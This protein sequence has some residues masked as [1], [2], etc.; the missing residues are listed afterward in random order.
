MKKISVLVLFA[1][2][3]LIVLQA[4]ELVFQ[5]KDGIVRWKKNNQ[6]VA[7]FGANY[8]LPSSCDYRAAGY[9]NADRKAMVREDMDHFKRMGWD[10]LRIC[11]WGDFQNSDPDGH[12]IDNDHL[13]MMDYLIAEASRRGIYMLF[14][15]IV[16]Y[17]SQ[18]PEMNDNSNTGYAKLF[19]KNT[20][21]HDE[22]AIKCQINYMTDIL[23]HVNRYTGRCIKDEPN[24]IYV[25]IINEPTQFPNDIPGMVKYINCMCKA[26][27]STGC[28]KLIYYNLSQNFDVAPA[29]QKSMV[30][31]AT[32]AWYPQALNNGH[33]FIDNGLHFVDRYEPL[34]KD[35]LK[36]KSRLVYEFDA[37]DTE[38]GYLLPAMTREYRRGG[39]QFATM[40]SYDEHQTASRNLSW[41]THFLNMVYTPSKAIGGMISA[42]VMKRIPR[43]KHY[44]YYPQNNNFGDFKVDFYQ[45]LGQLNAEDMF[46]Y[47][48]NTTD[49]PKNVKALKHIAGVGSSPVVQYEGT[50]IYFIDKVADNEWKLEVY[51]DIMNV[52]DPFKAGSVNRVARQAVCLNRNIHIQLPGLQTALCIYPGKYTF[53]NN[54]LVNYEALPNQEYYNKEAMKDWKVNNSTL[55]EMPQSRPGVFACEVYGPTLPKQV[56]LYILSGWRGGKRIPMAHKSGFRYETEVDL[57]KY[58][59][60]E[61][62]YHFGIEYTDGKLLFPA[63][64]IG[65]A[66]EFG[67][68][69]QEQYNLRI[70]NNNTTLTLLDKNDNIRK[71]RRSRPH[72]SPDNQVSQ[73]YVGDEMVKAFRIT[74][75]DL[76]RKDTYKLPCDVTLSKYISP[77]IDSR[78]WKTSTP[79]Y[80]RIEAQ[81]L[82]NTD[83]AII[84]F[85]DTEGRGYGN[86]F[87][88]KPDMQQILIP[89]SALR[90]TKG[91][92]LPQEYPGGITPYYYPASTRDNDNVP[93]KWE[94][95]DF[96]QI[97]LRDEIYPVE[98]LKDKGII[99]KK[100]QLVF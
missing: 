89:V 94:N 25:E 96:V 39:I 71:L 86:T 44:G 18:F 23:N 87:S 28:K 56:N 69:E 5:D 77:L 45:D 1:W 63:K 79:K 7:L 27:K 21:I 47:S 90:P 33:R 4:Q 59:L 36:G 72:N 38:N 49:Q 13:N 17:D 61:I 85:I 74:T 41:Q 88:I 16:T 84:N 37:T 73:V 24:I 51:P 80:I 12:L 57:S 52:D 10:A 75:P 35:G 91:V 66:D 34:V 43:G 9:V 55:T 93:L 48:N 76:E 50:G 53:K 29:I 68:Y 82:T 60:G 11:F 67:Y 15:P 70:V 2:S 26:I 98:Q 3:L 97:S 22:K 83:K 32:Y 19:A 31:G 42:Q 30:D 14:S 20:L 46:Y 78:D 40:F 99:I 81:G 95:I 62:G 6:E 8:C 65:V 54:L 92:I 100:I 58:P 64:I